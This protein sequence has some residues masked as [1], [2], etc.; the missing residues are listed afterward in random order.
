MSGQ[1]LATHGCF[2]S[3]NTI[4]VHV[5]AT[6]AVCRPESLCCCAGETVRLDGVGW[7]L[8]Y[9]P[10]DLGFLVPPAGSDEPLTWVNS[11]LCYT[12]LCLQ[13]CV[14][15]N[16]VNTITVLST[17]RVCCCASAFRASLAFRVKSSLAADLYVFM[18][19]CAPDVITNW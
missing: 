14:L 18:D 19:G 12:A 16:L 8:A 4:V 11:L 10:Q 3:A 13:G 7:T 9:S 5:V 1:T 2:R 17:Q 15:R 6:S